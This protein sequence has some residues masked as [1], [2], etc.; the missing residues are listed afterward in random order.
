M[1]AAWTERWHSH[2]STNRY[3]VAIKFL[4]FLASAK[5]CASA[6]TIRVKWWLVVC[7]STRALTAY[8]HACE[9]RGDLIVS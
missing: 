9:V 2:E 7:I 4:P 5:E 1:A 6:A 8:A 3:G